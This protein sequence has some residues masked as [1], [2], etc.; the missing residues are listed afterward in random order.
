[1]KK[2][3]Y[4]GGKRFSLKDF[5]CGDKGGYS[6]E[7]DAEKLFKKNLAK[8]EELQ[9]K[10]YAE[11]KEGV[12]FVFQAMDAAGKDGCIRAVL[13]CLSPQ[14]VAEHSF[15][16]P[17]AEETRHDYLWRFW[18]ALPE[19]GCISIFNR[20][21]YEDVLTQ[22]VHKFYKQYNFADRIDR[23]EII[24][25]RYDQI[26]GFERYLW[27]NSIRVVKIFLNVSKD[28]Q[29]RRFISRIDTVKKHWKVSKSDVDERKYWNENM[30][31]FEECVNR[32][33]W[34]H[35]PWYVVPADHKWYARLV[36][37]QIILDTL[38]SMDP[39]WPKADEDEKD[40]MAKLR[41]QLVAQI[42]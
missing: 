19:K 41:A 24:E 27:E 4:D 5:D 36:V 29:A 37:S 33:A 26:T 23:S 14:G 39:K 31:A 18:K 13:S 35:A 21:Y 32:T 10:L 40:M 42:K 11:K 1:M 20:S 7:E 25:R 28:E 8:I 6:S 34:K 22:K 15:K 30:D 3:R 2:Y 16:V 38:T 12:I 9:Q 17:S